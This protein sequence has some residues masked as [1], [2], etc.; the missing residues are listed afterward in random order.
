MKRSLMNKLVALAEASQKVGSER[1]VKVNKTDLGGTND[2]P[3]TD[4]YALA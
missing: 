1:N 4:T 2:L 3:I